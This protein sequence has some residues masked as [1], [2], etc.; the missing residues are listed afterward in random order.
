MQRVL[1]EILRRS[2]DTTERNNRKRKSDYIEPNIEGKY[3]EEQYSRETRG[4]RPGMIDWAI[5]K[6]RTEEWDISGAR[7]MYTGV[8]K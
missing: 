3:A 2:C 7:R 5:K 4:P 8:S 6:R 1:Y